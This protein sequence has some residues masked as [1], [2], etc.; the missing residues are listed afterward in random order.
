MKTLLFLITFL[1]LAMKSLSLE[2]QE[3]ESEKVKLAKTKI[4]G[5]PIYKFINFG[6]INIQ[7]LKLNK[8]K[9]VEEGGEKLYNFMEEHNQF[10]ASAGF[11]L[12]CPLKVIIKNNQV[13]DI[14]ISDANFKTLWKRDPFELEDEGK[15]HLV[16]IEY[17]SIKVGNNVLHRATSFQTKLVNHK[18]TIMK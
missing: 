16:T 8:Q 11:D 5:Y 6:A 3:V 10:M 7:S 17:E 14:Y 15:S 18:P 13:M 4:T 9:I 2:S 12:H 1:L